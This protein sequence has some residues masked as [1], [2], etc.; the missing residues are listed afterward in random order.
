[1]GAITTIKEKKNG[2]TYIKY[3]TT[4]PKKQM[5]LIQPQKGDELIFISE[6]AGVYSFR[7][8]RKKNAN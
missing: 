4:L 6:T 3:V 2:K 1:M 7:F 5:D 8:E